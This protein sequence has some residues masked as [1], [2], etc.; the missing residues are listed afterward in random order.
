LVQRWL[1][2]ACG[3][4][5]LGLSFLWYC[6][7][8]GRPSLERK[9]PAE[10]FLV[11]P[12]LQ[13]GD[14]PPGV[15]IQD[16][17]LLWQAE[18]AETDWAVEYRSGAEG[19]W[20]R[21]E[22]PAMRRIAVPGITPHR[23]YRVVLKGLAPGG[24]FAYRVRRGGRIRFSASGR[25]PRAV[26]QPYR[27]VVFG[28]CAAGTDA[29][30]AIAD[31]AY[32]AG[33]DFVV[34]AGDIVYARGRISEYRER[35]WPVY[36]AEVAAPTSGAPLLRSTL[37]V[38][39]P[40]NH[41]L[42][43][44]DL[45]KYPDSL[46]YFLYWDQ[47]RNGPLGREGGPLVPLLVAPA[48]TRAA[49]LEAAGSA[50][51]RTANFSFDY[52]NAHWTVLDSNSYVDWTDPD[53]RGWV[54]RDLAAARAATWRFVAFHHP[55]FNS[56]RSH[57]SDQRMR[58]LA[59]VFEAGRV[60]IVWSG[61]VHNYQRA[62]PLVFTPERKPYRKPDR[63]DEPVPGRWTLDT[64]YDGRTHT[65]PQ[66]VIYLITGAGGANLYNPE[67]QDDPASWQPFTHKFISKV[68]SLTVADVDGPTLTVRQ[69]AA[70][71]QELD[72]FVVTKSL[73]PPGG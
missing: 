60:D 12:Y 72:R 61:H 29:S 46:A 8:A 50:Y 49:F 32:R 51:P 68:H 26:G 10:E 73:P 9:T 31:Q 42:A 15:V 23:V 47:P 34:I 18:D 17:R 45:E 33:P 39:V 16:L 25:A 24:E 13:L 20:R 35:F 59:E 69:I 55:G 52:G 22:D 1:I 71:G 28:D 27:F 63:E 19:S 4:L 53:L 70:D 48:A 3:L 11:Q 66:G 41:D 30:K 36:N 2:V 57:F 6:D 5:A 58:V 67:Q 56:A 62:F 38:G 54:E 14:V 64:V 65:Q 21:A 7:L 37:F 43:G 40:G 44:R